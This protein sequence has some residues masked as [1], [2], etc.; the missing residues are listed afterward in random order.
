M[1]SCQLCSPIELLKFI[2]LT[3]I[4]NQ[5][6][7]LYIP[8]GASCR[9]AICCRLSLP[10]TVRKDL[11]SHFVFLLNVMEL[12]GLS[13]HKFGKEE[14]GNL[15][16]Y[17]FFSV[18]RQGKRVEIRVEGHCRSNNRSMFRT[19]LAQLFVPS[20]EADD[21]SS[22][23]VVL[24]QDKENFVTKNDLISI[25]QKTDYNISTNISFLLILC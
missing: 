17:I 14:T 21:A 7:C 25:I 4:L 5:D 16:E 11:S 2:R 18:E 20:F 23:N 24:F 9:L 22:L 10:V 12:L 15:Q 3:I 19:D 6:K 8:Q 1:F 13:L